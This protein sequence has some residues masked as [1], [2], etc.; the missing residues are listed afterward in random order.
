MGK[1]AKKWV[2][3]VLAKHGI[4]KTWIRAIG[5]SFLRDQTVERERGEER[6]KKRKRKRRRRE[7]E[8]KPR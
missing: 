7:E 4:N 2:F 3:I 8:V 6:E 1:E 5:I